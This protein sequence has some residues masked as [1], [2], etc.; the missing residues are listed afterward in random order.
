MKS[1]K[2]HSIRHQTG[3]SLIEILVGLVIGLLA[4]LV[5]M[6]VFSV[7]EGQKRTT[8]GSADAQ[9][10]GSIALYSIAS[11]LKM[12]GYGLL[13]ADNSPIECTTLAYD[14]TGI[15]DISPVTI[16]E[17]RRRRQRQHHDT[18]WDIGY[19]RNPCHDRRCDRERCSTRRQPVSPPQ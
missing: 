5:I 9:T 13:P 18:L 3:F 8:T 14:T 17:Y 7:F 12:A 16:T 4:T 1:D 2:Q 11:E 6:Q 10:N 19:G 15:T